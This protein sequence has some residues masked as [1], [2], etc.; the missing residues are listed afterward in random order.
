MGMFKVFGVAIIFVAT[1][2]LRADIFI[3]EQ[4]VTVNGSGNKQKAKLKS[5][6]TGSVGINL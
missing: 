5:R 3:K 4:T 2:S 6:A 1:V